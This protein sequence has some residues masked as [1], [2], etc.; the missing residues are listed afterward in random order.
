MPRNF[1][2]LIFRYN[3][4]NTIAVYKELRVFSTAHG[5]QVWNDTC[6]A[7]YPYYGKGDERNGKELTSLLNILRM[8]TSKD[9][10]TINR[11]GWTVSMDLGY[12]GVVE[13]GFS[14]LNV[15]CYLFN[16]SCKQ[17]LFPAFKERGVVGF[18]NFTTSTT[19]AARN[20]ANA[21]LIGA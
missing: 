5:T 19:K 10:V 4:N 14:D 9:E 2:I 16:H 20:V 11:N 17:N 7:G 1:L 3:N 21:Y 6:D 15:G 13:A 18:I 8:Y 12:S